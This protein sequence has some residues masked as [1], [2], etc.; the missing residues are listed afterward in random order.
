MQG[1]AFALM[2]NDYR[3]RGTGRYDDYIS[4]DD[5]SNRLAADIDPNGKY[6]ESEINL[7]NNNFSNHKSQ[8]MII[9]Y[10]L[11]WMYGGGLV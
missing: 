7:I 3:T 4:A 11:R 1:H 5:W 10:I 8:G 6:Q 9:N 2:F